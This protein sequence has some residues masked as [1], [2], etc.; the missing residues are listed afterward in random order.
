[1]ADRERGLM[2]DRE[3]GEPLRSRFERRRGLVA[4]RERELVAGREGVG[5]RQRGS[6]WQA[7]DVTGHRSPS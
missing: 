5:G 4:G 7:P 6:W 1:M 2:A 3:R